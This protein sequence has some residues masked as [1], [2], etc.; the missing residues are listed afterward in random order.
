MAVLHP[1]AFDLDIVPGRV[2]V[3]VRVSGELDI[4]TGPRLHDAVEN[5]RACG[6]SAIA[7]DLNDLTFIDS[8]GLSLLLELCGGAGGYGG[9]VAIAVSCPALERLLTVSKLE[10]VVPR[11]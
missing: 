2:E 4:A 8:T 3:T 10:H 5:L 9:E 11:G 6:W 7:L 1:P